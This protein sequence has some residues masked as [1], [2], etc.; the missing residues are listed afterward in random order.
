MAH[1]ANIR[2][3]KGI[4]NI[5]FISVRLKGSLLRPA[6]IHS[7]L[8]PLVHRMHA[9]QSTDRLQT[10]RSITGDEQTAAKTLKQNGRRVIPNASSQ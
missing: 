7:H 10:W 3:D 6:V 8:P 5:D 1:E 4:A 2:L 9:D